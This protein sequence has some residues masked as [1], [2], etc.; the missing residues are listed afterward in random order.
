[1]D[2]LMGRFQI[3]SKSK[4]NTKSRAILFSGGGVDTYLFLN[5]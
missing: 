4:L 3:K 2:I 1:M 5:I